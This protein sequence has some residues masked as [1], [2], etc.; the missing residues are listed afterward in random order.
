MK[1]FVQKY[2]D[3]SSRLNNEESSVMSY[4][5]INNIEVVRWSKYSEIKDSL[6][7]KDMVVGNIPGIYSVLEGLGKALPDICDYPQ[8][9]DAFLFRKVEVSTVNALL[10]KVAVDGQILF[11]KPYDSLKLFTG[12]VFD[13]FTGMSLLR[14]LDSDTKIYISPPVDLKAEFRV[15]VTQGSVVGISRYDDSIVE[16]LQIDMNV[17]N[18]A[19]GIIESE[20]NYPVSYSLDFGLLSSGETCLI[21]MNDGFAIGKYKDISDSMYF[22]FLYNRWFEIIK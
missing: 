22:K 7:D 15:Y 1:V 12:Q 18:D 19:V 10:F 3:S 17:V 5:L 2:D 4:C 20:G 13:S 21:E 14:S 8:E 9:L 16:D 11:A 6:S